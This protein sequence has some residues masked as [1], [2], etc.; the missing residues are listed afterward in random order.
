MGHRPSR[1]AGHWTRRNELGTLLGEV[2]G[3]R[4]GQKRRRRRVPRVDLRRTLFVLPNLITLASIFCGFNAIRVVSLDNPTSDDFYRAAILLMFAMLFDLLDGRVARMTRTQSAFGLQLDSL[5]D[6]VSFGVAPSVLVYKWVL[7]RYPVPG[8][9]VGFMFT[10]CGA[11]R[12]ARFNVLA[13]AVGAAVKPSKYTV[14]LPIP[15]ASGILISL[16][17]ANHAVGGALSHERYTL[18]IFGVTI[19]LSLFMV[20][21]FRFRSFKE[22][23][24][25][26][27][28]ALLVMFAIGSSAF[29]WR[30]GKPQFVLVWLL[31]FYVLAGVVETVRAIPERFRRRR[32]EEAETSLEQG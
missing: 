12:L 15:P 25:N 24:F 5:A 8:L 29:V 2:V 28:T 16:L 22:L 9:F 19:A 7:Y 31:S 1:P 11:I 14:G 26:V 23:S 6:I 32:E 10:A 20:S 4:F 18:A 3:S 30:F 17:L 21:T 13:G 27:G